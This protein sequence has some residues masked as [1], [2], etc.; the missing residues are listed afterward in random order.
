MDHLNSIYKNAFGKKA[1][2][3]SFKSDKP[4]TVKDSFE[5]F[6]SNL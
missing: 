4:R 5:E 1:V 6:K 3:D 2:N